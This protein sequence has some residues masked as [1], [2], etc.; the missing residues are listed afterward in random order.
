MMEREAHVY[1]VSTTGDDSWSGTLATA[2]QTRT[3]GPFATIARARDAIREDRRVERSAGGTPVPVTVLIRGG[4]YYVDETLVFRPEDGGTH[5]CPVTYTSYP[6]ERAIISGGF[7]IVG[8]WKDNPTSPEGVAAAL[9]AGVR[10]IDLPAG[11]PY[12]RGL[13]V[14]GARKTRART[15]NTGFLETE[16]AVS[17]TSFRYQAGD[18]EAFHAIEDAEVVVV[19]SWNESRLRILH[20]D[21]ES[22]TVDFRD[23]KARH[24]IGWT[25]SRGQNRY[26]VENIIE[27]LDSPGEWYFDRGSSTLYYYPE[28]EEDLAMATVVAPKLRQLIRFEGSLEEGG[29]LLCYLRLSGLTFADTDW[30]LP[31]NGYPDCGDVGDIV[32][33]STITFE[34]AAYCELRGCTIHDTGT[35]ALEI[36]GYGNLVEDNE[37]FDTGSGGIL[38]RNYHAPPNVFRYNHIHHCGSVYL[39][40]VGIN[41][42]DG[43]GTYANNL[44]HDISHSG[45]YARHWATETQAVQRRNQEQE[46]RVEGNEIYDCATEVDDAGGIFIRDSN[47]LIRNNVIHDVHSGHKRCPG[48]GIYLGCE[49]RDALVEGNLVYDCLESL[50]VWYK[51]RNVTVTNNIFVGSEQYQ[52]NFGNAEHLAHENV[53]VLRN[54]IYCTS[55]KGRLFTVFGERSLPTV[56]D[57]NVVFSAIGC[58]LNDP[59]IT[60][61]EGVQSFN[62]WRELGFDRQTIT[63]DPQFKDIEHDDYTLLPDSPAFQVGFR[64]LD[65]SNVGLRGRTRPEARGGRPA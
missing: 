21:E 48:W 32:D 65:F 26:Y 11:T 5:E 18:M 31:E 39:S 23:P 19:H 1:Y 53:R 22:R 14:D 61:L 63:A 47:I 33:P 45:I 57:A 7:P 3:D 62:D 4:T 49:T 55:T 2:N 30:E 17:G 54:V 36:N 64:A 35:Y 9:P 29:D 16:E 41:I 20:L 24:E 51:D 15:P 40:A 6:G 25:G 58:V 8:E 43:G 27:G 42:D 60:K 38:A 28:A 34:G 13:S 46:L 52:I 44:I 37:I 12:F 50:H 59:V 10:S 56:C